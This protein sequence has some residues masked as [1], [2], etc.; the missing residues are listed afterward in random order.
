[1]PLL[2]IPSGH[3]DAASLLDDVS[4]AFPAGKFTAVIG[5]SGSGKSTITICS[6]QVWRWN[7]GITL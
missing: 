2:T 6:N 4:S 7:H 1:M 5:P 3:H